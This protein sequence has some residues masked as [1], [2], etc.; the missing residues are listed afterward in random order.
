MLSFRSCQL[1]AEVFSQ[2]GFEIE[3]PWEYGKKNHSSGN[4]RTPITIL[5]REM[6]TEIVV[7]KDKD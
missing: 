6:A 7:E 1:P 3:L 4:P 2:A 5:E